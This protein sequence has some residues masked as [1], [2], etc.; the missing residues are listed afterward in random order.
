VANITAIATIHGLTWR[1]SDI[2]RAISCE[3]SA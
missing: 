2:G 3:P 1:S